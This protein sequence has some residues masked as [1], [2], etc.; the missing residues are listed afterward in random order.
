[1]GEFS[2]K[3]VIAATHNPG[4]YNAVVVGASRPLVNPVL[5]QL[6]TVVLSGFLAVKDRP[7]DAFDLHNRGGPCEK[8][9]RCEYAANRTARQFTVTFQSGRC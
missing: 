6:K 5:A 4:T 8:Q 3:I 2:G 7:L 1:M 9:F